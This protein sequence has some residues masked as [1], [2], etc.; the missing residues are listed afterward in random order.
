MASWDK[1]QGT[2]QNNSG[3]LA[4]ITSADEDAF[5]INLKNNFTEDLPSVYQQVMV[6]WIGL[7]TNEH[8]NTFSWVDGE[9][10]GYTNY[11]MLHGHNGM[12]YGIR[13]DAWDS[14]NC[15]STSPFICERPYI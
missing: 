3:Y 14:N 8:G 12:C 15:D 6:Y 1:A 5:V 9:A 10:Y 7:I 11:N 4:V 2:C 13:D